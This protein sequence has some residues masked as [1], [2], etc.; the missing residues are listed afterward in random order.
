VWVRAGAI[1]VSHPA[2]HVASGLGDV[3]EGQRPLVAT[4]WGEPPLGQTG[5]RLSDG[6]RIAW[7]RS[8]WAVDG[9]REVELVER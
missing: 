3:P 2:A 6:T 9:E 4:L 5:V 8:R 7:R 1:V